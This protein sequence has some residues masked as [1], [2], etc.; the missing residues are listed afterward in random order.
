M[1]HVQKI[2]IMVVLFSRKETKLLLP[3]AV[4]NIPNPAAD[5]Y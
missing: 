5:T 2:L 1:K 4:K 3:Q